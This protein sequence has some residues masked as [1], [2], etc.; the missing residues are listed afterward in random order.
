LD[1]ATETVAAAF[2]R[3]GFALVVH[4]GP[5]SVDQVLEGVRASGAQT[6]LLAEGGAPNDVRRLTWAL[7]EI[8]E[9]PLAIGRND[10]LER[11]G[12]WGEPFRIHADDGEEKLIRLAEFCRQG[13]LR[14]EK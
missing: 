12:D 11:E 1:P 7:H 10:P 3:R 6:V 14:G 4:Q 9:Y 2:A 5:T 8:V 13:L